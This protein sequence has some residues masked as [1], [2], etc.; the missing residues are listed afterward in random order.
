M[1]ALLLVNEGNNPLTA[2][3]ALTFTGGGGSN[4]AAT[5]VMALTMVNYAVTAVGSGYV[6]PIEVRTV[7]GSLL[8]QSSGIS[9][10]Q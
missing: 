4:A 10:H 2:A 3:P 9:A 1:T 7:G 6:A 5:V 8:T